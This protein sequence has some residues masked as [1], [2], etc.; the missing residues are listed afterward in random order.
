MTTSPRRSELSG[1][2][3]GTHTLTFSYD[4]TKNGKFAYDFVDYL[5]ISGSAGASVSWDAAAPNPPMPFAVTVFVTIEFTIVAAG[6][7]T[8]TII[9]EGHIASE[10]DYGPDSGAGVDLRRAVPLLARG[11]ELWQRRPAG[12]PADG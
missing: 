12:Q 11:P 9:W 1:L 2:T 10:L 4:R 3:P 5:S 6:D 7:E 8:A